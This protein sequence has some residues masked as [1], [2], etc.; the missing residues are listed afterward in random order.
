VGRDD[1]IAVIRQLLPE[2]RL[3][4][5]VRHLEV[6][7]SVARDEA[8]DA[9][10]VDVVAEFAG[11]TTFDAYFSVKEALEHALGRRVDLATPAMLKPRLRLEV[12]RESVRVS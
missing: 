5:G 8:T 10:D 12:E 4:F 3:R 1:A 9:S 2:L 7:G 6:F 11:P